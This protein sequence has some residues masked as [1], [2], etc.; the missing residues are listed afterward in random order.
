M[1]PAP[2][3]LRIASFGLVV[4]ALPLLVDPRVWMVW[5]LAWALLIMLLVLD[6]FSLRNAVPA[7]EVTL[8]RTAFVG[9]PTVA[10]LELRNKLAR[11][12]VLT[13]RSE[14]E[15]VL[16]EGQDLRLELR[17]ETE[18]ALELLA[19][20]RGRGQLAAIWIRAEGRLGLLRVIRRQV[21][22][23]DV[24]VIPSLPAVRRLTVL[25]QLGGAQI[26]PTAAREH[27][28]GTEFS[29]LQVYQSGMD[30]R[31]IDWKASARHLELRVRRFRAEQNQRV[32]VV[33]DT[34]RSM[35]ERVGPLSRLDHAIH[36]GL[37]LAQVALRGGDQVGLHAYGLRPQTWVRPGAGMTQLR[38]LIKNAAELDT[39]ERESNPVHGL[40][41]LVSRLNRRSLIVLLSNVSDPTATELLTEALAGLA[42]RHL[43]VLVTLADPGTH[44]PL[45]D[46]PDNLEHVTRALLRDDIARD[47]KFALDRMR[48]RGIHVLSAEPNTAALLVLRRYFH[49]KQRGRL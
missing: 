40:R 7:I 20:D 46:E 48:N 44:E 36:I 30:T 4:A 1:T 21:V 3:L 23:A 16:R 31:A 24:R 38:K 47:R 12:V 41:D 10:K 6:A 9:E 14:T 18:A 33:L 39:D 28:D 29:E 5:A 37:A 34:G 32:I 49:V 45:A 26:G 27:G 11:R 35:R 17:R 13:L 22:A 25:P 15:G 43:V 19:P 2:R 42:R 8:P